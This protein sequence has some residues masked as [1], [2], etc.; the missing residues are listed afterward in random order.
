MRTQHHKSLVVLLALAAGCWTNFSPCARADGIKV[1]DTMPDLAAAQLEG[2]LPDALKGKVVLLDFWASWC[3]PCK[4]SFPAMEELQK[5]YGPRGF[6]VIAVN[7]DENRSDMEDFLKT[8][9]A[10]FTVVHDAAQKL[11]AEAGIATMPS[12]FLVDQSGR[13]RFAHAGFHGEET[14]KEYRQ[15]IESLLGK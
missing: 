13:V 1:G 14:K 15:E 12:S 10:G 4:Q 3:D 8:H 9:T 6:V 5:Q 7:V 11:V 2:K